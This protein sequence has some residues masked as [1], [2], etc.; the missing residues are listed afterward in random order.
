MFLYS[1]CIYMDLG[2]ETNGF[3][4]NDKADKIMDLNLIW[5][6]SKTRPLIILQLHFPIVLVGQ[7]IV[8]IITLKVIPLKIIQKPDLK[9]DLAKFGSSFFGGKSTLYQIEKGFKSRG[10]S[11][12]V[13]FYD[14]YT[15][16]IYDKNGENQKMWWKLVLDNLTVRAINYK[17][18]LFVIL[19]ITLLKGLLKISVIII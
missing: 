10:N 14:D 6:Y 2:T 7:I 18:G 17:W 15:S 3:L 9:T 5:I 19:S 1:I 16:L 4:D 11:V 8:Y 12:V 13:R